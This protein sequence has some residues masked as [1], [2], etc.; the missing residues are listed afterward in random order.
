DLLAGPTTGPEGP[1]E[2]ELK[3][4]PGLLQIVPSLVR[5]V[6]PLNDRRAP[7]HLER[8]FRDRKPDVV[9]THSGKA[10]VLGR[11]AAH[12]AGVPVIVH[13]IH[14]P[15]FGSFQGPLANLAFELAERRAGRVT[16]HF[17]SVADAMTEQ[18]LAAGIGSRDQYSR[19]LSGFPLEPFLAARNDP[20]TRRR[21]GFGEND[22]VIGMIARLFKL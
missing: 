14:G 6:H 18:Y 2:P 12:R 10:G 8:I 15:S 9:H 1:L 19:I 7:R 22:F 21:L 11:L 20:E 5:P 3:G 16:T 17:I 4:F 13:T